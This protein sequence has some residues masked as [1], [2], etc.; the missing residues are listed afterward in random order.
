MGLLFYVVLLVSLVVHEAA[1]ALVALWGGDPTAYL[2][3]QVTLNPMPHIRRE[4]FGMVVLPLVTLFMAGFCFGYASTPIDPI[5]AYRNPKKAAVMS[6]AG[7][8]ANFLLAALAFGFL[9]LLVSTG[10][11]EARTGPATYLW[12]HVIPTNG[13]DFLGAICV[14]LSM[15]ML[16]N[17]FLGLF[18]LV[19]LPPLDGA[20]VV[21]GLFQKKVSG[22]YGF[23]RTQPIFMM[24][25]I[26]LIVNNFGL[27]LLIPYFAAIGLLA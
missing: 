13:S 22:F 27:Y 4:P 12:E 11:A 24:L 18:N 26:L 10:M 7:P 1:H 2:G 5:W 9:Y 8:V 17:I 19:P 23:L 15:F 16:L 14:M 6:L 3:G 25:G 20:G 21:E